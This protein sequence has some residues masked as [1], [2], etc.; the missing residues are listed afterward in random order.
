MVRWRWNKVAA[1]DGSSQHFIGG[2]A[3]SECAV[4]ELR[5]RPNLG[6]RR[7]L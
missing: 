7:F 1:V 4:K 6:R 3:V 5:I 2:G